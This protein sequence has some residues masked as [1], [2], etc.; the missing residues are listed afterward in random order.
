MALAREE[1]G[2]VQ[3]AG[4]DA[5][6]DAARGGEGDGDVFDAEDVRAAGGSHDGCAHCSGH[7]EDGGGEWG[8]GRRRWCWLCGKRRVLGL[9][10]CGDGALESV[11]GQWNSWGV[12]EWLFIRLPLMLSDLVERGQML[13]ALRRAV[14]MASVSH[15][16]I[17]HV[18]WRSQ[19][20]N[21]TVVLVINGSTSLRMARFS[22][23]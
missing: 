13:G 14:V 9:V 3:A 8:G 1:F 20:L 4:F 12:G 18:A 7:G 5:D 16:V 6:E 11:G 23:I 19:Y 22:G 2:A 15:A 21:L 10:E 17:F